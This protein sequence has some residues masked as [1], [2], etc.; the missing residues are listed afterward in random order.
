M[1]VCV[2]FKVRSQLCACC[3][4]RLLTLHACMSCFRSYITFL[5]DGMAE[6]GGRELGAERHQPRQRSTPWSLSHLL[7]LRSY[8]RALQQP[9]VPQGVAREGRKRPCEQNR[10]SC[11]WLARA[12]GEANLGTYGGGA[13]GRV[14]QHALLCRQVVKGY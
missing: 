9:C 8:G 5:S 12:N 2:F 1:S 3:S 14:S 13:R 11:C 10:P 7:L 4:T 6:R